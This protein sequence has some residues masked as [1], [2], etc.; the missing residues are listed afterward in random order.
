MTKDEKCFQPAWLCPPLLG[1]PFWRIGL[2]SAGLMVMVLMQTLNWVSGPQ[3]K[4]FGKLTS[5]DGNGDDDH[6]GNGNDDDDDV[7]VMIR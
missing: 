6:G 4:W 1:Q 5:V 7:F 3:I 2:L